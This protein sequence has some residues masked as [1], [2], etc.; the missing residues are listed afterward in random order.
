MNDDSTRTVPRT[1]TRGDAASAQAKAY[2]VT[3]RGSWAERPA[4]WLV[5][6]QDGDG[7]AVAASPSADEAQ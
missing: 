1:W 5:R 4:G 2:S 3:L 7:R 6:M